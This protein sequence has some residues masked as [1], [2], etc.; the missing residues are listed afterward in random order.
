MT[1]PSQRSAPHAT[2]SNAIVL[3][4]GV[5]KTGSTSLQATLDAARK[6]LQS[7]DVLYPATGQGA[8]HHQAAWAVTGRTFGFGEEAR[9]PDAKAWSRLVK[10]SRKYNHR[11]I[12]SSEFFGRMRAARVRELADRLG[13]DRLHVFFAV[14]PLVDLL[15][16]SWQQYLKSGLTNTY[17]D[18]LQQMLLTESSTVTPGFWA[19]ADFAALVKR[20]TAVLPPERITAV[21]LDPSD[22]DLLFNTTAALLDLP[23][24]FLAQYRTGGPSNRSLTAPEAELVRQT[25]LLVRDSFGWN[26]YA[27][28]IRQGAVKTIVETRAVPPDE[29][30]IATPSWAIDLAIRRQAKDHRVLT[31]SGIQLVGDPGILLQPRTGSPAVDVTEIPADLAGLG[32]AAAAGYR[33]SSS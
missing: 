4:I 29:Q 19:R 2:E 21:F 30:R 27:D 9:K 28:K 16:S 1:A 20:W 6:A 23:T 11:V 26:D 25:N 5:H 22:R 10:E 14:R 18:W 31:R 7:H 8:A 33:P 15:P 12:I 32:V 3:H 13:P 24:Q 17:Q